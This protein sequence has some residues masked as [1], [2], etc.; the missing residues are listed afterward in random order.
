MPKVLNRTNEQVLHAEAFLEQH[1]QLHPT[2]C[3]MRPCVVC[4]QVREWLRQEN[5]LPDHP[6]F[7]YVFRQL[8]RA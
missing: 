1:A 4:A 3:F 6:A 5:K 7:N 8:A 2:R